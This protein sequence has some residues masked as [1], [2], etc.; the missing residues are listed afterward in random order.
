MGTLG[1]RHGVSPGLPSTGFDFLSGWARSY[2]S[3]GGQGGRCY[4]NGSAPA[5]ATKLDA[6]CDEDDQCACYK[7][8]TQTRECRRRRGRCL[9]SGSP[10]PAGSTTIQGLCKDDCLCVR[11]GIV[12]V[13]ARPVPGTIIGSG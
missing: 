4:K 12:A 13:T 10:L 1:H 9:P 6:K 8:C 11:L 5:G 3:H 2:H 7:T